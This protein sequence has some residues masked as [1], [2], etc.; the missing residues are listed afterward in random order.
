MIK[1]LKSLFGKK[2]IMVIVYQRNAI[3]LCEVIRIGNKQF[4]RIYGEW[5]ILND[6]GT[7]TGRS[8][9]QIWEHL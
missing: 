4:V 1:W 8:Y 6:D 5:N 7:I 2:P 9:N 3:E